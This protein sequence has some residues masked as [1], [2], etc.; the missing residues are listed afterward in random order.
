MD[1]FEQ[2]VDDSCG[3]FKQAMK[4][5]RLGAG[6]TQRALAT[7]L[8]VSRSTV[9]RWERTAALPMRYWNPW[10]ETCGVHMGVSWLD[11]KKNQTP[12]DISICKKCKFECKGRYGKPRE[13]AVGGFFWFLGG[14]P[15]DCP[16][17]LDHVMMKGEQ[18]Q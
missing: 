18:K 3:R 5:A 2:R 8:G 7:K 10:F 12:V 14:I 6:F 4:N 17:Y 15:D 1:M 13:D 9:S 16:Y 11:P